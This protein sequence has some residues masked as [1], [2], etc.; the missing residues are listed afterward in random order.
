MKAPYFVT[1]GQ[2]N[3]VITLY[4]EDCIKGMSG[5]L[6]KDSVD[7]VVTSPPYNIGVS[8]NSYHDQML[9]R[10]Y[11]NW[12]ERV[13]EEVFRVLDEGGSF[14][15]NVG[16]TPANPWIPFDIV[17]KLHGRFILQKVIHWLKS[18][19]IGKEDAGNYPN[20]TGDIAV[21]HY[22]PIAGQRF[23][24]DCHEY[25]FHFTKS[26]RVPLG[27]LA[28]GVP[29]QDK[30]NVGRW[31]S[32]KQDRRCRGNIWFIPYRTIRNRKSQRPHPSTSPVSLPEM[33]L[34]L[35]G[36]DEASLVL[37]P[38]A[39][40]GDTA[41]ACLSLGVPFVGFDIDQEYLEVASDR[42]RSYLE[43]RRPVSV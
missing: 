39:G 36:I 18:I 9:D 30:S 17:Q 13:G 21:G 32:A 19:A 40:I 4:L 20:I 38:F 16:G 8:Y 34:R 14:F 12:L 42:I 10:D 31:N 43:A 1:S 37:D 28:V 2:R 15:L 6:K 35:H 29:Y 25:I 41:L 11:L 24:N 5:I 7:V 3:E 22:K 26:G 23:L 27:R 33:C